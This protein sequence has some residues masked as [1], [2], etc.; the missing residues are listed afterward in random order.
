MKNGRVSTPPLAPTNI[1]EE[2]MYNMWIK[3]SPNSP[4][5]PLAEI[6][7]MEEKRWNKDVVLYP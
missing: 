1:T 3:I 2:E 6:Q 7:E 4:Q 5:N